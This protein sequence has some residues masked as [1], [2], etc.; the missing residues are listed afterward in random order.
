MLLYIA[1]HHMQMLG[2]VETHERGGGGG[3]ENYMNE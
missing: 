2:Q 3:G 1:S